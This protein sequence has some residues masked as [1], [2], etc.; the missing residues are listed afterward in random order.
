MSIADKYLNQVGATAPSGSIADRLLN[1]TQTV[2]SDLTTSAGLYGLAQAQGGQVA[3]EA[4]QIMEPQ[5]TFL[6]KMADFGRTALTKTIKALNLGANVV[7]GIISPDK[8]VGEAVQENILPADVVWGEM[9]ADTKLGKAGLG[10]GKFITNVLLDPVTYVTFGAGSGVFGIRAGMKLGTKTL[11]KTGEEFLQ[12]GL[13]MGLKGGLDETF[14]KTA[15]TKMLETKPE[16]VAQFIDKGGFKFFGKTILSGQRISSVLESIPGM[17]QIDI[18]T[19]PIRNLVGSLFDRDIDPIYGKLPQELADLKTK[20]LDMGIVKTSDALNKVTTIARANK[21]TW[22]EADIVNSAI[23]TGSKIADDRLQNVANLITKELGLARKAEVQRGILK[24]TLDNY[25]PHQLVDE[26]P[27]LIP[28]KP[29]ITRTAIASSKHRTIEGAIENIN[30]DFGKEFFDTNIIRTTA[31]RLVASEKATT[32]YDFFREVGQKFGAIATEAPT[33]YIESTIKEL[34]G[35][36]FHPAVANQ[37][38]QFNKAIISDQATNQLLRAFDKIQNV[39]KSSVTSMFPA[40]HGRNGISNVFLNYLDIGVDALNPARHGIATDL[41]HKNQ[42]AEK[43][44]QMA[45]GIGE[46]AIKAKTELNQLLLQPILKDRFGYSWTFGELRS[47]IKNNRVAFG[48]EFVGLMDIGE[49]ISEKLAGIAMKP[50]EKVISIAGKVLPTSRSFVGYQVGRKVGNFIEEEARLVNF[51]S[52]LRKTG[53]P[54][55]AASRAKQFLFDYQ[56]LTAFERTFLRRLIPFYTFTRKNLELQVKSLLTVPG[57]ISTE[58]KTLTTIGDIISGNQKLT[59]EDK[60]KLPDWI[61]QGIGILAGK[62]G[63]TLTILGSLQTPFEQP[64]QALQPNQIMGSISPLIR[65]PLEQATGYNF[66]YGKALSDVD[67][68]AG[69]KNAPEAVKQ[70]IGFYE[71]NGKKADGTLFTWYVSLNPERMNLLLNMPPFSRVFSA[72]KQITNQDVS[73]GYRILQQLTGVRPYSFDLEREE[74]VKEKAYRTQLED[75]L[76]KAGV[77]YKFQRVGIPK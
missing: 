23:E 10:I 26:S 50:Q 58:V 42:Q 3:S 46:E 36:K 37:L 24:S 28:F 51:I 19:Q 52:N 53:D 49:E 5:S 64:F 61:K 69:F 62:K 67:N 12:K 29:G 57:R 8:T 41:L 55:L 2:S 25:V 16:L 40:F 11:T 20:Y 17:K 1:P 44:I 7:A 47:L 48:A 27:K 68:A 15:M 39:W 71:V 18:A 4:Q 21:L 34:K 14:V 22:Q 59:E 66:F 30:A 74:R 9:T 77:V 31:K 32:A 54:F 43:L 33:N 60:K 63:E 13:Q 45:Y 73:G 38:S 35:L 70:F 75:L 72:I 76:Q 6:G 65:A 56:N